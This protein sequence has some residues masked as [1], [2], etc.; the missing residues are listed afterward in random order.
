MSAEQHSNPRAVWRQEAIDRLASI[1]LEGV[2]LDLDL[3]T[4]LIE[5]RHRCHQL[6]AEETHWK[7]DADREPWY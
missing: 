2:R 3:N 6:F 4:L 7:Y 5:A 1:L